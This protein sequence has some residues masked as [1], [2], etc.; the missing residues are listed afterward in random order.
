MSKL[1]KSRAPTIIS[2]CFSKV[3]TYLIIISCVFFLDYFG[4]QAS[5]LIKCANYFGKTETARSPWWICRQLVT[6]QSSLDFLFSFI[7]EWWTEVQYLGK[8]RIKIECQTLEKL[9]KIALFFQ[10]LDIQFWYVFASK[11]WTSELLI[12]QLVMVVMSYQCGKN[13][14][15]LNW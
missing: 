14:V 10:S 9:A 15:W 7:R 13:E 6:F 8:K 11:F 4:P 2:A 5:K 3:W 1:W 12:V